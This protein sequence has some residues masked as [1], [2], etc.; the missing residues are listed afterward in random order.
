MNIDN[1]VFTFGLNINA[2]FSSVI[3]LFWFWLSLPLEVIGIVL[4]CVPSMTVVRVV[5]IITPSISFCISYGILKFSKFNSN[6]SHHIL[7]S[8]LP[9]HEW[10][11]VVSN[12]REINLPV[13]SIC[14]VGWVAVNMLSLWHVNSG[15][16]VSLHF[17]SCK[18]ICPACCKCTRL[19][20]QLW[21]F[22]EAYSIRICFD[23][24]ECISLSTDTCSLDGPI[25]EFLSIWWTSWWLSPNISFKFLWKSNCSLSL[26]NSTHSGD[27]T[28][29]CRGNHFWFNIIDYL[30]IVP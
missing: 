4:L 18:G 22:K 5:H 24:T 7:S 15:Y 12:Y 30:R 21:S 6:I 20:I 23:I 3:F 29:D 8:W 2:R 11:F 16:S 28:L 9:S 10:C 26:D 19:H 25:F 1:D 13:I 17:S 27:G 14:L